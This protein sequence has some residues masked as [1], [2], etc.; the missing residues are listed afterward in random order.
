MI[1]ASRSAT[2]TFDAVRRHSRKLQILLAGT[3]SIATLT[4]IPHPGA[5]AE[6]RLANGGA[7]ARL[8]VGGG[9]FATDD[10]DEAA[11]QEQLAQQQMQQA[12]QQAEEQN[13]QAQ[14]QA[15]QAEQQG[16]WVQDHP[17]P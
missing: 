8:Q 7:P 10:D 3:A 9:G 12:E 15:Q 17:G 5:M 1:P 11:L 4:L 2:T 14:Q 13:E 6:V 16:Q